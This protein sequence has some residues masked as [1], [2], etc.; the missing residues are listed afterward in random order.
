MQ[1]FILNFDKVQKAS[2]FTKKELRHNCIPGWF[3]KC[4][5]DLLTAAFEMSKHVSLFEMNMCIPLAILFTTAVYTEIMELLLQICRDIFSFFLYG[6][7]FN[8]FFLNII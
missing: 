3:T 6:C 1:F 5:R 7:I 2:N 4:F 8:I